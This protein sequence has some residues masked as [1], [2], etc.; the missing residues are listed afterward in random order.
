MTHFQTLDPLPDGV[1]PGSR[2]TRWMHPELRRA[3]LLD[4]RKTHWA[5][6]ILLRE[7]VYRAFDAYIIEESQKHRGIGLA[8]LLADLEKNP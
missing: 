6:R 2:G 4:R 1:L 7:A 8:K 5:L 3:Y